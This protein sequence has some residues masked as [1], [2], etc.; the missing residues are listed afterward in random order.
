MKI[1]VLVD[2]PV[3]VKGFDLTFYHVKHVNGK[4]NEAAP[5]VHNIVS[6]F[7][8]NKTARER[9]DWVA[10][11]KHGKAIRANKKHRFCWDWICPTIEEYNAFL[12]ELV[13]EISTHDIAGVHLDCV[14]FPREEYCTCHR[15]VESCK[16]SGLDWVEWRSK[17]VNEFVKEVS[18]LARSLSITLIPDPCFAK[19]R[20]GLNFNSLARYVDFFVVPLYDT[21]YSTTYWAETLAYCFHRQLKKPLYIELY[22]GHPGLM[23]KNLL[24]AM[25]AVSGYAD[26]V[27]LATYNIELAK[28]I[29]GKLVKNRSSI[30]SSKKA[31]CEP[32]INLAR[33]RVDGQEIG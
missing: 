21:A 31:E 9:P 5:H 20:F 2:R 19:E 7:G 12:F 23:M 16:R 13:N 26:G 15:C 4:I 3:P 29:Q 28:K 6:C 24:E 17:L 14:H 30:I 25:I 8:D 11:S 22:A 1:G 27:I 33:K 18:K 32:T 10:V